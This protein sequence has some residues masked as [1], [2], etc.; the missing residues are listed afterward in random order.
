VSFQQLQKLQSLGVCY[1][2]WPQ[3]V[4]AVHQPFSEGRPQQK[5]AGSLPGERGEEPLA[6]RVEEGSAAGRRGLLDLVDLPA[7]VLSDH[8]LVLLHLLLAEQLLA[9]HNVAP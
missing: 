2:L 9:D 6:E 1:W 7:D 5:L 3:E 4:A 8:E